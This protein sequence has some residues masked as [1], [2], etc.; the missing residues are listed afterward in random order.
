MR[1]LDVDGSTASDRV[2]AMAL[3]ALDEP[4]AV[5]RDGAR[6]VP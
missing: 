2:L 3:L 1:L 6:R 5:L 4:E